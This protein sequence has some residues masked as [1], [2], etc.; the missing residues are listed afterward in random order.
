MEDCFSASSVS[1]YVLL[2]L[3][4]LEP[5]AEEPTLTELAVEESPVTEDIVE[6]TEPVTE[7]IVEPSTPEPVVEI[8]VTEPVVEA[9]VPGSTIES[10]LKES[11]V[12]ASVLEPIIEATVTETVAEA[13]EVIQSEEPLAPV[14]E[15]GKLDTSAWKSRIVFF[16]LNGEFVLFEN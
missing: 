8:P 13:P 5:V 11:V 10:P 3:W 6:S 1:I 4:K 15:S 14:V 12:K 7:P 16:F 9:S 2:I